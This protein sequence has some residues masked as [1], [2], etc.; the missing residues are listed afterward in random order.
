MSIRKL[1]TILLLCALY[2]CPLHAQ[3]DESRQVL[4]E[5]EEA[6]QI[7]KVEEAR[8]LLV[9]RVQNMSSAQRLSGHRL[10]TLCY[11]PL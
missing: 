10:P 7:G 6:N 3:D 2:V 9:R 1:Y 4:N 8:K 11:L 5:A